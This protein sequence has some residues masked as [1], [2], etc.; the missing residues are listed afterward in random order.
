MKKKKACPECLVV[1]VDSG[2]IWCAQCYYKFVQDHGYKYLGEKAVKLKKELDKD[3]N[4]QI[5]KREL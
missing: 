4:E 5:N 2:A 3:K 1:D